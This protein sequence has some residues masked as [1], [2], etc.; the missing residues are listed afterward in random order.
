MN[1]LPVLIPFVV[2]GGI[3]Y[4]FMRQKRERTANAPLRGEIQTGVRFATGLDHVSHL[5]TGGVGALAGCGS[6]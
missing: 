2:F 3:M 1:P 6:A 5:G 4:L